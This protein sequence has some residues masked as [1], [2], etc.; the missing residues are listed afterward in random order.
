M[1]RR[2]FFV[3]SSGY[4][5][6]PA[7]ETWSRGLLTKYGGTGKPRSKLHAF[8]KQGQLVVQGR[9]FLKLSDQRLPFADRDPWL[10]Q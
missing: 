9:T 4:T 5:V 10:Q 7:R 6:I 8:Y 1:L 3:A 2:I